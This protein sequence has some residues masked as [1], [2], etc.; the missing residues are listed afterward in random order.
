MHR[1]GQ[2]NWIFIA[3][4]MV[5][6]FVVAFLIK[7]SMDEKDG[8]NLDSDGGGN[9]V[10][11]KAEYPELAPYPNH[12]EGYDEKAQAEWE[13]SQKQLRVEG[14]DYGKDYQEFLET[15]LML[16][17]DQNF[18]E[19]KNGVMSPLSIYLAS[20]MLAETTA[21]NT[22][23]QILELLKTDTIE[24]VRENAKNL[25]LS[26]YQDDGQY[27]SVLANSI[28]LREGA[29]FNQDTLKNITDNYY[30]SMFSGDTSDPAYSQELRDWINENTGNLLE[31]EAEEIKLK[32]ETLMAIISTV[33]FN[34]NWMDEFL[35]EN[36]EDKEFFALD[37][38]VTVPF[39]QEKNLEGDYLEAEK[40]T[41]SSK[42]LKS[43]GKMWFILPNEGE[44]VQEI[45]KDHSI[46]QVPKNNQDVTVKTV[47]LSLP[48]FDVTYDVSLIDSLKSLGFTDMFDASVSDFSPLGDFEDLA[49]DEFT[50]AARIKVDEKGVEAAAFT[51]IAIAETSAPMPTDEVDF[52][53]D[54][55]FIF[56]LTN[57][58][59]LV[60]FVGVVNNP[61]EK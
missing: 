42:L 57:K 21:N 58:E 4:A 52:V 36:T 16:I 27:T 53:L 40:Y 9:F 45:L 55:P 6:I 26:N 20:S 7:Q 25:W 29:D 50:H 18:E 24:E 33:Y 8:G 49:V 1:R 32:P 31:E 61:E 59:G 22:Q 15:Y 23:A 3:L 14:D 10:V 47:N 38:K 46:Y 56:M 35:D 54:R 17:A 12:E 28:W 60:T 48:K 30:A 51:V 2:R 41:A 11:A 34:A 13:E 39:M 43:Y 19:G 44:D 37:S 5:A